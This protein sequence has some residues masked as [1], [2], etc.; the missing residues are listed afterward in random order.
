MFEI[1]K[2]SITA[3]Q[4]VLIIDDLLATGGTMTAANLLVQ[5]LGGIVERNLVILELTQ[6]GGRKKL[7]ASG[8]TVHSF[9]HY[10]D[11]E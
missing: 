6:L 3:G 10:D 11:I 7:E 4:K 9:I 2:G 1:Q 8:A 5:Q